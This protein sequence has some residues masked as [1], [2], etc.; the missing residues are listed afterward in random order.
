MGPKSSVPGWLFICSLQG[1]FPVLRVRWQLQKSYTMWSPTLRTSRIFCVEVHLK[2]LKLCFSNSKEQKVK[3]GLAKTYIK[4]S[5]GGS[6]CEFITYHLSAQAMKTCTAQFLNVSR[7]GFFLK[8]DD[9]RLC[10]H[11]ISTMEVNGGGG[12]TLGQSSLKYLT[13]PFICLGQLYQYA[14]R[15]NTLKIWRGKWGH[16]SWL[17]MTSTSSLQSPSASLRQ[18]H[19]Y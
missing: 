10:K 17:L 15:R 16:S 19:A 9:W 11:R 12:K 8:S 7:V 13:I 14:V 3:A 18:T 1:S 2:R 6:S 4:L 5:T